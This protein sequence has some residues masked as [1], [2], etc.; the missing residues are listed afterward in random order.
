MRSLIMYYEAILSQEEAL[1][2]IQVQQRLS[3]FL[4]N[5]MKK[6][7]AF[8]NEVQANLKN[9]ENVAKMRARNLI[10]S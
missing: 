8:A 4:I 6:D 2:P 7:P 10:K 5:Y 1:P 9:Y 3:P